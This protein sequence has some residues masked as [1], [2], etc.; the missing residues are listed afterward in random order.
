MLRQ[1]SPRNQYRGSRQQYCQFD[2]H[3]ND[4]RLLAVQPHNDYANPVAAG[5]RPFQ[6][7]VIGNSGSA[8]CSPS[9]FWA[10]CVVAKVKK[11]WY[12]GKLAL[13]HAEQ[14]IVDQE[15]LP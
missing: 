11:Q 9:S 15:A 7:P 13:V 3:R 6:E 5:E 10:H 12:Q 2:P 8:L 1:I 4:P 14:D